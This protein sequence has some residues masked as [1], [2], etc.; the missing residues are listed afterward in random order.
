MSELPLLMCLFVVFCFTEL[1]VCVKVLKM[2]SKGEVMPYTT[3]IGLS[4]LFWH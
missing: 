4:G 1:C 2:S 3:F